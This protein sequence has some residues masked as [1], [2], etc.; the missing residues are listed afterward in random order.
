MGL[1][2]GWSVGEL[3][4][5]WR[6]EAKVENGALLVVWLVQYPDTVHLLEQEQEADVYLSCISRA[7]IPRLRP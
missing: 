6:T 4:W 2:W 5:E 1:T 7:Y 3:G